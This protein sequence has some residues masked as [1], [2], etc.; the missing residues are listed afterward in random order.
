VDDATWRHHLRQHDVS[1]WF[2]EM[3]KDTEL[4][5]EAEAVEAAAEEPPNDTRERIRAA[6]QRRY[7]APT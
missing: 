2:R 4:A 1:R 5:S 3:I 7:S 6:I